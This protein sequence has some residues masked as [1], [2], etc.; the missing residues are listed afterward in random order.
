MKKKHTFYEHKANCGTWKKIYFGM[1]L[2]YVIRL[3]EKE[4]GW[5]GRS[6]PFNSIAIFTDM[7]SDSN[8]FERA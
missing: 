1:V 2:M 3:A 4:F 5:R 8:R 6:P 7:I